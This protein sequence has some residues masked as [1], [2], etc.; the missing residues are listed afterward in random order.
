M[1]AAAGRVADPRADGNVRNRRGRR[2][3]T[4]VVVLALAVL[5]AAAAMVVVG[6]FVV[7]PAEVVRAFSGRAEWK[8]QL[9]VVDVRLPRVLTG[10][11]AGLAFGLSGAIFQRLLHNPLA[12]PDIVGITSGASAAAAVCILVLGLGGALVSLGAL[13]GG[14]VTAALIPLLSGRG[15][16]AS[17]HRLVLVGIGLT[18]LLSGLISY[19]LTSANVSDAQQVLRW[20]TGSLNGR[21]FAQVAALAWC[22]ALAL[23]V[24][25]VLARPLSML[26]LGDDTARGLG[27]RVERCRLGLLVAAVALAAGATAAAGPVV[28]VALVSAPIARRLVRGGTALTASALVGALVTLVSDA[29]AQHAFAPVELPVGVVTGLVGGPY[30]LML[31]VTSD[32]AGGSMG[33]RGSRSLR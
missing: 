17:G 32:R 8:N 26:A 2:G 1:S 18:A 29:V 4:A 31:L 24:V 22:T 21:T 7:P 5:L 10:L 3:R 23:P 15:A 12:S 28:F 20:L 13:A 16:G 14:L 9:F 33:R 19:L 6:D 25:A 11:L 30:L 27:V